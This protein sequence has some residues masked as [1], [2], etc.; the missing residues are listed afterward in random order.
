MT[1]RA[2]E[3][4]ADRASAAF[5]IA[6]TQIGAATVQDALRIWAGVPPTR[7][8]ATSAAWLKRA[9]HLVLTRRG[10]AR[11]LAMAYYRLVRALHTGRTA[12][13]PR[14]SDPPYVTLG[15]LRREFAK[16]AKLPR[17]G[18]GAPQERPDEA[19]AGSD[20]DERIPVERIDSLDRWDK[21]QEREGTRE[22]QV[23]LTELGPRNLERKL[24]E[25][26]ERIEKA[27][28]SNEPLTAKE[29]DTAREEAHRSAGARQAATAE[30]IALNGARG[31]VWAAAQGDRRVIGYIRVSR[32]GTPCGWCAMLLSRGFVRKDAYRSQKAAGP[33]LVQLES[34]E[35][36]EGDKYHDNCQCYAEPIFAEEQLNS[37]RYALNRRYAKEWPTVTQGKAGKEALSA[38]RRHVRNQQKPAQAA[39]PSK[40]VQEA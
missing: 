29:V 25:I 34:G 32:T 37:P 11:D 8:A 9:V 23:L 33:T 3:A 30:R 7:T 2:R 35:F 20:N 4:E 31:T 38:W 22:A 17:A 26:D 13:D 24:D 5:H 19:S 14:K 40:N 21:R 36:A 1:T 18:S 6:L 27:T 12:A 15:Q 16:L 28:K 10:L 39:R